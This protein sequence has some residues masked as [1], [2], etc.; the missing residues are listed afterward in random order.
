VGIKHPQVFEH[1]KT[2]RNHTV[3]NQQLTE[4]KYL[5]NG[6]GNPQACK[7]THIKEAGQHLG[8]KSPI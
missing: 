4:T 2:F 6:I 3:L 5:R 1:L 7:K 8:R